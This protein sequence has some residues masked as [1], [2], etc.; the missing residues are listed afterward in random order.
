MNSPH[1]QF[2]EAFTQGLGSVF[3]QWTA[4]EL[5][6]HNQWGGPNSSEKA[7]ELLNQIL[8]VFEDP[9]RMYKDEISML[10]E[11]YVDAEFSMVCED[12]SPD[13]I[14]E[15][16]L[17]MYREA[18]EGNF[19]LVQNA[20]NR[21]QARADAL[22]RSQGIERGDVIDEPIEECTQEEEQTIIEN[23]APEVDEDGFQTVTKGRRRS[24]RLKN[25]S[26]C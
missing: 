25:K 13:E 16:L 8:K 17:A 20:L 14:A 10:I 23:H 12:G 6:V 5:A 26:S 9:R 24:P 18:R 3:R 7:N 4:L 19:T 22:S 15:L 11:D 21:E 2:Q 1:P